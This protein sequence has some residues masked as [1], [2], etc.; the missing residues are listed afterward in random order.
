MSSPTA[1]IEMTPDE[2]Q[3]L[4][5]RLVKM[6][7][8]RTRALRLVLQVLAKDTAWLPS[9]AEIET[10][11]TQAG[12]APN[13][14]TLYRLLDRLV[15]VG[16]LQRHV[17]ER[18]RGRMWRYQW[19]AGQGHHATDPTDIV[20]RFE[21][22]AC[23]RQFHLTEA[24]RPTQVVAEQLLQTLA[25]LGHHGER[26]DLSIHGTCAVCIEPPA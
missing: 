23:H 3:A 14:V 20:P 8:R 26:V 12:E 9:H 21:C 25:H 4:E 11:L 13:R 18:G 15:A 16:V 19:A 6:G 22:D 5:A 1:T 2:M 10:V 24:S 17:D 7:L